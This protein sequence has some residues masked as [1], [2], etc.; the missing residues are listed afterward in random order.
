MVGRWLSPLLT[1]NPA[2]LAQLLRRFMHH[3][4]PIE[5]HEMLG[6]GAEGVV[7]RV[8]IAGNEY[9]L[10]IFRTW[11]YNDTPKLT[12]SQQPY[13]CPFSHECR[14]FARLNSIGENGTWAVKCHG[15]M[16]LSDE[17]FKPLLNLQ[18]SY[19][20]WAIVKDY[21]PNPVRIG[22]VPEIRRKMAIARKAGIHPQDTQPRNYRG[23][24]IVDLGRMLTYPYIG[25]LWSE[26]E[27]RKFFGAFDAEASEWEE[28][29]RDGTII[30]R[31]VNEQFREIRAESALWR[32]EMTEVR[33]PRKKK[34]KKVII[35]SSSD[36]DP[37]F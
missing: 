15:W 34:K 26:Y 20:R 37:S 10:K 31:W 16:K 35:E 27:Y 17:Q 12:P 11:V 28:S 3:V 21:I 6:A 18:R 14:A 8:T 32:D 7:Y 13:T 1:N 22:D 23:S 36:S 30:P 5:Y 29:I 4:E 25:N 19:S 9:A 2:P 33:L 24:F